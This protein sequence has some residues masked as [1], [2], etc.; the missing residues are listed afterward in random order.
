MTLSSTASELQI[1]E[2]RARMNHKA[3]SEIAHKRVLVVARILIRDLRAAGKYVPQ[4]R[5]MALKEAR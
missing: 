4:G 1:L 5:L 2:R 3:V